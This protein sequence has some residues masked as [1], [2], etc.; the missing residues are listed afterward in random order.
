M[1]KNL[2]AIAGYAAPF[3]TSFIVGV[4]IAFLGAVLKMMAPDNIRSIMDY[5]EAN[6]GGTYDFGVIAESAIFAG[7]F[8][9]ASF[10]MESIQSV[11]LSTSSQKMARDMKR[12]VNE[13]LDRLPVSFFITRP[14]GDLQ[15]RVT[16]DVDAV[17][18]AMSN[19]LASITT[20]A[21]TLVVCIFMMLKTNLILSG[22]TILNSLI[23]LGITMLITKKSKPFAL[24]QQVLMGAVNSEVYESFGGHLVIKAFNCEQDVIDHFGKTNHDLSETG[25]KASFFQS[26][27]MPVMSTVSNMG[28]IIVAITGTILIL[29][30]IGNTTLGDLLVFILYSN[31]VTNPL[32]NLANASAALQP[33]FAATERIEEIMN[34][35]E[36]SDKENAVSKNNVK[37]DVV[38][39]HVRFGYLP[40]QIILKD[41]C[42]N[43]KAGQKVAIVGPTGAGK[44]TMVNLLMRFYQSGCGSILLDG[45][46]V[47]DYT[48]ESLHS[49]LGMVLQD[50]WTFEGTIRENIVYSTPGVS[51]DRLNE[52][53]S[54]IGL[55]H[56]VDTLPNGI[57]TV[58]SESSAI[59][60]GQRQLITIGRA[61]AKNAP[62]LILDEATSSVDTRTEKL[63]QNALDR[64]TEGR[65][66]FV[67]AHRLSTIKNAD[68]I[69]VMKDGD[70]VEIGTHDELLGKKGL[71]AELYNSQ[72]ANA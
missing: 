51:E 22:V 72:F 62:V 66:S 45:V 33:A 11:I 50:T 67:I 56:F 38:F 70:V 28:Y 32:K 59:S 20:A 39:D 19:N 15:S 31:Q 64:L 5:L 1:K 48:N 13:K 7:S 10:L 44:S 42:A 60:A 16:N 57:D 40:D 53:I 47:S 30:N 4:V 21:T 12:K 49:M 34:E 61:M 6:I 27:T 71:Y 23:G 55:R 9:L 8:I 63:I 54:D 37:G 17:A 26:I 58:I 29:N 3:K 24:K 69:F 25:W 2:L 18:T 65:T 14:A 36:E 46:P 35:P 43:V 68:Q 41:L 52:I